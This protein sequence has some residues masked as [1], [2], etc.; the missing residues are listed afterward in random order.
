[1]SSYK[2]FL[3][4]YDKYKCQG[5]PWKKVSEN[6]LGSPAN[7][8]KIYYDNCNKEWVNAIPCILQE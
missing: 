8:T 2:Y 3:D 4:A 5:I 1:M 6:L 7:V